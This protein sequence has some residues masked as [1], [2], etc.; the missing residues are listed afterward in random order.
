M[1][2]TTHEPFD[3]EHDENDEQR[4]LHATKDSRHNE[5]T[6]IAHAG[7]ISQ[8]LLH[9]I[10]T[11]QHPAEGGQQEDEHHLTKFLKGREPTVSCNH[12]IIARIKTTKDKEDQ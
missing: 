12:L 10:G 6:A 3:D 11:K 5:Q 9:I 8:E 2:M 1:L 7:K 4:L